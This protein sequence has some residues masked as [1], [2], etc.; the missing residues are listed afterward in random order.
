MLKRYQILLNDWQGEHYKM[1]CQKYDVS[2]SEMIRMAL[3][4]DILAATHAVFPKYKSKIDQKRLKDMMKKWKISGLM[5]REQ[6]HKFLSSIYFE[7]RKA[8]EVWKEG[9]LK[10]RR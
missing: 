10:Q 9:S 3:C 6:F 4:V 2:F 1:A 5:Q 8:T 7:A